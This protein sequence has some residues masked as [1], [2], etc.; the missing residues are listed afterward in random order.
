M[1]RPLTLPA[2]SL[3]SVMGPS[4]PVGVSR[5]DKLSLSPLW[6]FGRI[7]FAQSVLAGHP[8]LLCP[9]WL[10]PSQLPVSFQATSSE[11]ALILYLPPFP[12]SLYEIIT[13]QRVEK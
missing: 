6:A 10:A 7:L 9:A 5:G 3:S 12:G 2:S 1:R 13:E 8:L 11:K 4:A